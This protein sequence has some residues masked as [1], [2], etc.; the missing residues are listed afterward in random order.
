MPN[1]NKQINLQILTRWSRGEVVEASIVNNKSGD[2]YFLDVNSDFC[3][4]LIDQA[5]SEDY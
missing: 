4:W 1:Q 3:I 5:Y 2:E